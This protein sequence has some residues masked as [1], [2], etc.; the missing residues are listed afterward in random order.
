M[1]TM[2]TT[3]VLALTSAIL[4]GTLFRID[5]ANALNFSLNNSSSGGGTFSYDI[6]L[7]PGESLE[8]DDFIELTN[9]GGV[10]ATGV[11][12]GSPYDTDGFD[13]TSA[14]FI[15]VTDVPLSGSSQ[16]FFNAISLTSNNPTGNINFEGTYDGF[17][18]DFDGTISG[19]VTP[20]P[21]EPSTNLGIFTLFSIWGFNRYRKKLKSVLSAGSV[22]RVLINYK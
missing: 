21:F 19:P 12:T 20:V 9:L 8:E 5:A 13:S 6:T 15:V 3:Q 4:V 16:T 17:I 10:T 1:K 18:N 14:D 11:G 7:D 22:V 2:K